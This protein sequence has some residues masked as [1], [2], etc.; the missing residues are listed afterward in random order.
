MLELP[1]RFHH[2]YPPALLRRRDLALQRCDDRR[3][4]NHP[5]QNAQE[6]SRFSE[7][8]PSQGGPRPAPDSFA[9]LA[10]AGPGCPVRRVEH[11]Y[12]TVTL[13]G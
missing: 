11:K 10:Q 6:P 1:A 12:M 2:D 13:C 8:A 3:S 4:R 7:I 9:D 5:L